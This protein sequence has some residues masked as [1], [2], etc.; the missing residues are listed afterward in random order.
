MRFCLV[1]VMKQTQYNQ[2]KTS[3]SRTLHR[4]PSFPCFQAVIETMDPE[5][6]YMGLTN[7]VPV[8]QTE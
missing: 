1:T 8:S 5:Q 3:V 7:Q 6:K 2:G 4:R